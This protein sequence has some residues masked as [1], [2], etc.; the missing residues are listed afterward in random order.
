MP[1]PLVHGRA[2]V[3]VS[4]A[5]I[6]S[7]VLLLLLPALRMV[8]HTLACMRVSSKRG[9]ASSQRALTAL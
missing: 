7:T 6:G 5:Q 9:R 4:Y 2:L 8:A 3:Q 1:P